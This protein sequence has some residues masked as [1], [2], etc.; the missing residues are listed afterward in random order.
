M[1]PMLESTLPLCSPQPPNTF[2]N[3]YL[4]SQ[5]CLDNDLLIAIGLTLIKPIINSVSVEVHM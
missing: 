3:G 5:W 4:V 2:L 1:E